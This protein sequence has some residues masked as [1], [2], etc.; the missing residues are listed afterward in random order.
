MT[1]DTG[2]TGE[3]CHFAHDPSYGA[4]TGSLLEKTAN[5][6][7]T[8][9]SWVLGRENYRSLYSV[10]EHH[11]PRRRPRHSPRRARGALEVI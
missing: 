3:A 2:H 4:G 8:Y 10:L 1:S 9:G 6:S 5:K 11:L 7:H